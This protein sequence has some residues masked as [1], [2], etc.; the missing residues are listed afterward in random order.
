[1][2][3]VVSEQWMVDSINTVREGKTPEVSEACDQ[4][5]KPSAEHTAELAAHGT[6]SKKQR[7][8]ETET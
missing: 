3:H 5:E 2:W 8:K 4:T 1:M 7:E 6:A